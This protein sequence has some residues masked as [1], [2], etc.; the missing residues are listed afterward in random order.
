MA[1]PNLLKVTLANGD[2]LEVQTNLE[3]RLNFETALRKNKSWGKLQD[4]SM[5][6]M[7]YLAWSAL[8]RTGKTDLDWQQFT[9]GDTA[10]LSVDPV[11]DGDEDADLEVDGVGK[12]TQTDR[13]ITSPWSSRETTAAAHGIGDQAT[14]LG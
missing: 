9:T 7:P 2:E 14:D 10:A 5:K 4:N 8:R 13:S 1:T 3:D 12:D 6:L 11:E